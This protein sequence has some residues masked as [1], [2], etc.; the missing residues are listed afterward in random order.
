MRGQIERHRKALLPGREIAPVE[1][2]RFLGGGEA[3]VLADGPRLQR[4]HGG[5]RAAQERRN[6]RRHSPGAPWRTGRRRCTRASRG[7]APASSTVRASARGRGAARRARPRLVVDLRKIRFHRSIPPSPAGSA[8]R[9]RVSTASLC[10]VNE[11]LPRRLPSAPRS[12]PWD[13]P[14]RSPARS[15]PGADFL[16]Q[17]QVLGIGAAQHDQVRVRARRTLRTSLDV[18][19]RAAEKVQAR[20]W[21]APC[22]S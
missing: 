8:T 1:R 12:V 16:R 20:N 11:A 18:E 3:R 14:P 17:R 9:V 2:V 4:V 10:D 7:C 15:P 21:R 19:T 13:C 5:V 6:A 22:A